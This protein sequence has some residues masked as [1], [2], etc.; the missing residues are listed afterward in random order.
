MNEEIRVV[1]AAVL[2]AAL[3]F[4]FGLASGV[5]VAPR[6]YATVTVSPGGKIDAGMETRLT[7][8]SDNGT[9]MVGLMIDDKGYA[10]D[11]GI[12][13]PDELSAKISHVDVDCGVKGEKTKNIFIHFGGIDHGVA[14]GDLKQEDINSV[15]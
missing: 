7:F 10:Y 13:R 4:V 6:P 8:C 9:G 2:V 14:W 11:Y 5:T 12:S 1:G 3:G 15:P